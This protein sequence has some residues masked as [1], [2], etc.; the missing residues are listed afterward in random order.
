MTVEEEKNK[1]TFNKGGGEKRINN[2]F[3]NQ[4]FGC[5]FY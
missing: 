4:R 2:L 5:F 1:M 3:L